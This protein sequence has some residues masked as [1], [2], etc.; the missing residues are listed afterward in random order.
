[1]SPF[2]TLEEQIQIIADLILLPSDIL[3]CLQQAHQF[4]APTCR[5]FHFCHQLVL[6]GAFGTAINHLD[7]ELVRHSHNKRLTV[8]ID[9]CRSY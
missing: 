9:E 5:R 6:I 8:A 4:S 7:G 2:K 3:F 1:M